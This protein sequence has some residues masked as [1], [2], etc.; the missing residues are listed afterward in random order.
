VT[1]FNSIEHGIFATVGMSIFLLLFKMFKAHGK[2]LGKVKI[3]S[4]QGSSEGGS[5]SSLDLLLGKQAENVRNIF[6][7]LDR[8]DG[9]NPRVELELPYPGVFIY[10]FTEGFNYTNANHY[11]DHMVN[12]VLAETR[13]TI[14]KKFEKPGVNASLI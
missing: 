12:V 7:P 3:R 4:I 5:S 10:R 6:L 11:L 1:I 8:H 9:T 2:F 13:P 14:L